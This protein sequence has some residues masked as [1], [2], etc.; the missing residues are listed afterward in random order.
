MHTYSLIPSKS[1]DSLVRKYCN[2]DNRLKKRLEVA[3]K[4]L[5]QNPYDISLRTHKVFSP[6]IGEA[7]S[8]RV[9]SDLRIIWRFSKNEIRVILLLKFGGHS[10]NRAVY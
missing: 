2:R 8:S 3:L 10:G 5:S 6:K 7:F 9:T 1:F 4:K